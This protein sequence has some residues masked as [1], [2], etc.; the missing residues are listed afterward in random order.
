MYHVDSN[1]NYPKMY[2]IR[3]HLN[4]EKL[5]DLKRAVFDELDRIGFRDKIK[6]DLYCACD[7]KPWRGNC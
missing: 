5:T 3:Q 4:S 2:R 7:G 1:F 6:K